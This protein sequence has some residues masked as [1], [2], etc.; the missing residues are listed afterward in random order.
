MKVRRLHIRDCDGN[1]ILD[2]DE[3][4]VCDDWKS[5]VVQIQPVAIMIQM[6]AMMAHASQSMHWA[7]AEG[8]LL[9]RRWRFN[10]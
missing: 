7:H 1:C 2:F 8:L 6:L 9:G 10:L 5:P 3:D 4:G